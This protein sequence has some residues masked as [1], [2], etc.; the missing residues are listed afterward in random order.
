MPLLIVLAGASMFHPF[1]ITLLLSTLLATGCAS[2]QLAQD[3]TFDQSALDIASEFSGDSEKALLQA[4]VKYEAAISAQMKFYAPLHMVQVDKALALAR[5]S[6]LKG[7]Q[8]DSITASA[9]V[10]TLLQFATLNKNKVEILLKPLLQQKKILEK[11]NSP[12]VLPEEFDDRLEDI[13]NLITKIEEGK[14]S[15]TPSEIEAVLEDLHLLELETLLEIHWQPAQ[16]TLEK[17]ED[18]DADKNAPK[19]FIIAEK[20]VEKAE[21]DIRAQY[22]NREWVSEQGLSA[23]R[24]AQHALYAARD[25]EQLLRL[26]NERAENTVLRF[27]ALLAKI[28]ATLKAK[29]MRHMALEDQA[30]ALAQSAETQASR[31]IAP[32]QKRIAELEKQLENR[33]SNQVTTKKEIETAEVSEKNEVIEETAKP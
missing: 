32:L 29:D 26:N 1:V 22:S 25:A 19:T 10:I 6:E 5:E 11:I 16:D 23:L 18:E 7:L 2:K 12:R 15:I 17:A 30:T 28:G 13:K 9:K 3:V 24:A 27:E 8:S 33:N 20:L 4:E 14:E 21:H 31:L